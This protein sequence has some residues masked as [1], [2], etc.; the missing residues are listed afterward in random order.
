MATLD[1][2]IRSLFEGPHFAHVATLMSDGSPH[3]AP[4]WIAIEDETPT[5]AK[6]SSAIATTNLRRDPRVAISINSVEDP[7]E[8]TYVRGRA[9]EVHV[10]RGESTRWSNRLAVAYTGKEIPADVG[11]QITFVLFAVEIQRA[12]FSFNEGFEHTP[13]GDRL[14]LPRRI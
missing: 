5:F 11:A 3:V 6:A 12:G 13:P 7:Y 10:A 2:Q 14:Q 1:P 4:V 8:A 9:V